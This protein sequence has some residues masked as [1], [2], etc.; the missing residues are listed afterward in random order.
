MADPPPFPYPD[1]HFNGALTSLVPEVGV[2]NDAWPSDDVD[3]VSG[4][5]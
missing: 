1:L 3:D 4:I 2:G 5:C